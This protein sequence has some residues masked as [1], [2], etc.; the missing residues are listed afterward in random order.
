MKQTK[1][2]RP[3][4]VSS[5]LLSSKEVRKVAEELEVVAEEQPKKGKGKLLGIIGGVVVLLGAVYFLYP[6]YKL[7][8]QLTAEEASALAAYL[9]D[10]GYFTTMSGESPGSRRLPSAST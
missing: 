9:R 2:N 4:G 7:Y 8:F 5:W 1:A 6:S 10:A 3:T